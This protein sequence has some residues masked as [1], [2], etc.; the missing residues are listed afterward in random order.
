MSGISSGVGLSPTDG[1]NSG[2]AG[3]NA[4]SGGIAGGTPGGGGGGGGGSSIISIP[5]G[6]IV[7]VPIGTWLLVP[8]VGLV[9]GG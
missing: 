7:T 8:D 4:G 2:A 1:I 6:G 3:I 5:G 9:Y